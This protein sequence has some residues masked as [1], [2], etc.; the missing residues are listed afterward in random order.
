MDWKMA[1]AVNLAL[2]IARREREEGKHV[3][4]DKLANKIYLEMLTENGG[5]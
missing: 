1:D 5:F 4:V 2:D 3:D